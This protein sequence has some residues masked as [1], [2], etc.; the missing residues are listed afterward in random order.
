MSKMTNCKACGKEIAKGTKKYVHCGKVQCFFED[1]AE[2]EK[3]GD[4]KKGDNVTIEGTIN[5]KSL[6]VEVK[7]CKIK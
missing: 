7:K 1:K 2:A 6:N 4:L 5:G 3:V